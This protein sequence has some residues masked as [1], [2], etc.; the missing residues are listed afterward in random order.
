MGVRISGFLM[1]KIKKFLSENAYIFLY[2]VLILNIF[3]LAEAVYLYKELRGMKNDLNTHKEVIL[4][5]SAGRIPLYEIA[6]D[7]RVPAIPYII[8]ELQKIVE[9]VSSGKFDL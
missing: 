7:K 1:E 3:V 5:L 9:P 2:A 6:K 8:G 4:L